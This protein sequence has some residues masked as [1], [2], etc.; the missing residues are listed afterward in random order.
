LLKHLDKFY[1]RTDT[2]WVQ[3][4]WF[5]HYAEGVPHAMPPCGSFW[6]RDI[7]G[8]ADIFRG[9]ST[10]TI[11][12]GDSVLLWKDPWTEPLLCDKAARLFSFVNHKDVSVFDFVNCQNL[13][14]H[15][16][17][18]LSIEAHTELLSLEDELNDL[19]LDA[20]KADAW[21]PIWGANSLKPKEFYSHCFRNCSTPKHVSDIWKSKC[22]MKHKVFAWLMLIDRINTRD[23]LK[24]RNFNIGLNHS[25]MTCGT[26]VTE[27]RNHLFFMCSFGASCWAKIGITWDGDLHLENMISEA[28]R[29]WSKP[30][31]TEVLILG[32]W[33]IWKVRN[34]A[35][36]EGEEPSI[37]SWQRQL[38]Q[39]LKTLTCRTKESQQRTIRELLNKIS[40]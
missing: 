40:L 9:V 38:S 4:V 6:W 14:D 20:Q 36:F 12:A 22:V 23:M 37:V 35:C 7:I 27:T 10:V 16:A 34:R 3:L 31:F 32:A 29:I 1:K 15:L 8:L 33:N 11:G 39:D 30:L 26:G 13:E 17:L 25:C 2:P 21:K 28:K 18:P 24:R 19:Q 5:K